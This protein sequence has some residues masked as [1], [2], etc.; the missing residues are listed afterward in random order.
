MEIKAGLNYV[1]VC[2]CF[3][4]TDGMGKILIHQR[5]DKCR[6]EV[7]KWDTGSGA[8]EVG[9]T[10]KENLF[11]EIHE[12]FGCSGKILRE[13]PL[14]QVF[15]EFEGKTSHWL[16]FYYLVLVK[17][18]D[19]VVN[20]PEKLKNVYWVGLD[21]LPTPLHPSVAYILPLITQQDV[22]SCLT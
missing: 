20:E 18:E 15:R 16:A 9:L 22:S 4:L 7:G 21:D 12:E 6:D 3:I 14:R 2:T 13:L 10:L 11:K 1:G 19:V 8:L 5:S 17:P